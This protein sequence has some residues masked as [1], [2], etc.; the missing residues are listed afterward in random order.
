M[1]PD[2]DR[3]K[4]KLLEK[5]QAFLQEGYDAQTALGLSVL[6]VLN[7]TVVPARAASQQQQLVAQAVAKATGSTSAPGTATAGVAKRPTDFAEAF[8]RIRA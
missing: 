3:H 7:D 5:S 8:S 4:P 6:S 2:W 1:L